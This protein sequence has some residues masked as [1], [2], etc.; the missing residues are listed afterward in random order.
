MAGSEPLPA[1][2]A[3]PRGQTDLPP[4]SLSLSLSPSARV[5]APAHAP[6]PPPRREGGEGSGRRKKV[7]GRNRDGGHAAP[8]ATPQTLQSLSPPPPGPGSP[9]RRAARPARSPL[10][11]P[12]DNYSPRP[13][14]PRPR[15][16][17]GR[18]GG[19]ASLPTG[20]DA[21]GPQCPLPTREAAERAPRRAAGAD[22]GPAA[23]TRDS[24]RQCAVGASRSGP[25]AAP[26]APA[27]SQPRLGSLACKRIQ[28]PRFREV[29]RACRFHISEMLKQL[30]A[31]AMFT[32]TG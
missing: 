14:P 31:I 22:A 3:L 28:L 13:G 4:L 5:A 20:P 12:C 16:A 27:G 7:T 24:P 25:G 17:R 8:P 1:S 9:E 26:E 29:G 30:L 21:S 32:N 19:R 15:P 23:Q 6:E 10:P 18:T 11:L 2:L